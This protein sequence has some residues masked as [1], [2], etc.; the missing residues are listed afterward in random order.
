[1]LGTP[2]G[3]AE[4]TEGESE[5]GEADAGVPAATDKSGADALAI[6]FGAALVTELAAGGVGSVVVCRLQPTSANIPIIPHHLGMA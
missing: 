3:P 4:A 1:M 2:R 6:T 5:L